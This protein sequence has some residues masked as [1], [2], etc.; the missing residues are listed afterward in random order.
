MFSFLFELSFISFQKFTLLA[1]ES[2]LLTSLISV[3]RSPAYNLSFFSLKFF[4]NS[5]KFEKLSSKTIYLISYFFIFYRSIISIFSICK[6]FINF[7]WAIWS[8]FKSSWISMPYPSYIACFSRRLR[9]VFNFFFFFS[10]AL[11]FCFFFSSSDNLGSIFSRSYSSIFSFCLKS[12]KKWMVSYS[13]LSKNSSELFSK[14]LLNQ[15]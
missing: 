8:I 11:N 5:D 15:F 9:F 3:S 6:S 12:S 7:A 4:S 1:W 10:S 2:K 14:S 13:A